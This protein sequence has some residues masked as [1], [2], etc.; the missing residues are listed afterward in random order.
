MD[1]LSYQRT[2]FGYHGCDSRVANSVLE[3]KAKLIACSVPFLAST[4]EGIAIDFFHQIL[5]P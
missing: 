1:L 4:S 3:G 5:R 2:I